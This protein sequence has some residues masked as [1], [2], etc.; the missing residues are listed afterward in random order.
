MA[1]LGYNFMH[2]LSTTPALQALHIL[3]LFSYLLSESVKNSL[4]ARFRSAAIAQFQS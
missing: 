3:E 1:R 2:L 4:F